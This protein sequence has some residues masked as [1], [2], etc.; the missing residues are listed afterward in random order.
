MDI[1]SDR[2]FLSRRSAALL[3][4]AMVFGWLICP[5]RLVSQETSQSE[6]EKLK[7]LEH[8]RSRAQVAGDTKKLGELLAAEFVEVNPTGMVRTKAQNLEGHKSGNTHWERFDLVD[9]KIEVLGE[10]AIVKGHLIRKGTFGGR[11][12]SGKAN[13]TR[14]FVRR[15]GKWQPSSSTVCQ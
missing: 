11:D 2:T 3:L 8:E 15:D 4:G 14:Y 7:E 9:L 12:L 6:V 10:T 13:Y 1:T 5:A